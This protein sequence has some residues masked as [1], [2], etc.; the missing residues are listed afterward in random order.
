MLSV[1]AEVQDFGDEDKK[2]C[3]TDKINKDNRK[4][5]WIFIAY[6]NLEN[7][8][9]NEQTLCKFCQKKN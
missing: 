7:T 5:V 9:H 1:N 6:Q 3:K 2:N 4:E 8:K